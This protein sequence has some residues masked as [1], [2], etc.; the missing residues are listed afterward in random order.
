MKKEKIEIKKILVKVLKHH[1]NFKTV[2][3][4]LFLINEPSVLRDI[5]VILVSTTSMNAQVIKIFNKR[6]AE[7]IHTDLQGKSKKHWLLWPR[8]KVNLHSAS[9]K[10]RCC[11]T[12]LATQKNGSFS[13]QRRKYA[14]RKQ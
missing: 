12:R 6:L 5:K 2:Y 3:R 9:F 7:T 4:R 11:E 14:N 8:T 10:T 13:F 1:V